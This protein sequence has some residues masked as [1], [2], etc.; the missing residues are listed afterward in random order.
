[1]TTAGHA[2]QE[3][4][5]QYCLRDGEPEALLDGHPWRRF[6]VVGDSVAEGQREPTP[7]YPDVSWADR[8]AT[9]LRKQQPA[10]AYLNLGQRNMRAAQVRQQQLAEALGFRPDLALVA[11]GG[12]DLFQPDYDSDGVERELA[13]IVSAF[14]DRDCDVITVGMFDVSRS[15]HVPAKYRQLLSGRLHALSETAEAVAAEH[16]ALYFDLTSHPASA[17]PDL[18][19]SDGRHGT[20]RSHAIA[21]A[22][23]LR[24]LGAHVARPHAS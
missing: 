12:Y 6:V 17:S 11:C 15:P 10:L 22:E 7:G 20:G 21:A 13:V 2:R 18:Y 4:T 14:R 19:S 1:V 5:D 9:E 16:G 3:L 8:I 24:R 23:C